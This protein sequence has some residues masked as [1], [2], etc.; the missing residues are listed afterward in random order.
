MAATTTTATAV[1]LT[2]E[3]LEA[4][5]SIMEPKED[6]RLDSVEFWSYPLMMLIDLFFLRRFYPSKIVKVVKEL[7]E[8]RLKGVVYDTNSAN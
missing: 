8:D 3:E 2:P 1:V 7:F 4:K 6:E 5:L